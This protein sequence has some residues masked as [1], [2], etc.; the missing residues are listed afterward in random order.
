VSISVPQRLRYPF[1]LFGLIA[2]LVLVL[3][4]PVSAQ[5]PNITGQLQLLADKAR[6]GLAA[7]EQGNLSVAQAEYEEIHE[8]WET[9][10]DEVRDHYPTTYVELEGALHSLRETLQAEPLDP[11]AVRLAYD[12]LLD[13]TNEVVT[14]LEGGPADSPAMLSAAPDDLL[15][16]LDIAYTALKQGDAGEAEE[17]LTEVIR[18]WPS[19]EGTVAAQSQDA[20]TAIEVQLSRA[21]AALD[22]NPVDVSRAEAAVEQLRDTLAPFAGSQSYTMF[23]AAVIILR[24]GL[25]ALLVIVALLAFLQ[26]SGNDDKRRWIWFGGVAGVLASIGTAF[27]LQQV[28]SLASSGQNR[29]M[30]EGITSL[31]AAGLLFYVSYWLHSKASLRGW[32]NFINTQTSQALKRGS[33]AGL[34]LLAFLAVFREGAETTVFYLGMAPAITLSD[35][36]L[37]LAIGTTGLVAAAVLLLVVEIKLP[38]RFFFT[39]AGLL[40]YY[41]GFKFVGTGIHSLQVAGALPSSLV[42]LPAL[43]LAGIYPTWE[44]TIPQILLLISGLGVFLYLRAQSQRSQSASPAAV[45]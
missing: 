33:M 24:E 10:E 29:E 31:I 4:G 19:V 3:A 9:F 12:H 13:E 26:R 22:A 6:D 43:P 7:A 8:S 42:P 35:L 2:L 30:I 28:F 27:V 5:E 23:D 1:C 45:S 18:M 21:A 16:H 11:T 17:Q 34:A 32:Q 37:G 36:L 14:R 40:V 38:L 41:L 25:E 39:A 15:K 20:Y 44:T